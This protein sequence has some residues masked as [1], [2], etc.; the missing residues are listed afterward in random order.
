MLVLICLGARSSKVS[1]K[2]E[3]VLAPRRTR[4]VGL[5]GDQARLIATDALHFDMLHAEVRVRPPSQRGAS[6]AGA[7]WGYCAGVWRA[8][9]CVLL[10]CLFGCGGRKLPD[11]G[12]APLPTAPPSP[13]S[14]PSRPPP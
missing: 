2:Y 8:I 3:E 10:L 12:N 1:G 4:Y 14:P 7:A 11:P 5:G 13:V 9:L 6:A